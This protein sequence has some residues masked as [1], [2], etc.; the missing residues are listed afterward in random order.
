MAET[1]VDVKDNSYYNLNYQVGEQTSSLTLLPM[2]EDADNNLTAVKAVANAVQDH[3]DGVLTSITQRL[4]VTG[5]IIPP[6]SSARMQPVRFNFVLNKSGIQERI[7]I[8]IPWYMGG[9]QDAKAALG[10]S[11][12]TNLSGSGGTYVFRS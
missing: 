12:A 3:V 5:N 11:I 10:Q 1:F 2:K 6:D 9:D 8:F 4:T 7:T